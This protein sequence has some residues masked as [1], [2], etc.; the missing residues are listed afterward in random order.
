MIDETE[1]EWM[2]VYLVVD[3]FNSER[4]EPFQTITDAMNHITA[5]TGHTFSKA[6]RKE[7]RQAVKDDLTLIYISEAMSIVAFDVGVRKEKVN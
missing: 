4:S 2:Q 1:F 3:P 5:T 6:E 7:I